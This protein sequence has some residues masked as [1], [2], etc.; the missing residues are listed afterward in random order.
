MTDVPLVERT[1]R[2]GFPRHWLL[3][4]LDLHQ[5]CQD[6]ATKCVL[7]TPALRSRWTAIC[8]DCRYPVRPMDSPEYHAFDP[9]QVLA[10]M[11]SLH[12]FS[13]MSSEPDPPPGRSP[14]RFG[15]ESPSSQSSSLAGGFPAPLII[16]SI[17][18]PLTISLLSPIPSAM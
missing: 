7:F 4:R 14:Y 12:R 17:M 11:L 9:V 13:L 5:G 18:L 3:A 6:H 1:F 10:T 16:A 2:L 8:D 15:P